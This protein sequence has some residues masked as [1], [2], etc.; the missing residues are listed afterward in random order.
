MRVY[1][2]MYHSILH[3][4]E[5]DPVLAEIREFVR[6]VFQRM[7]DHSALAHADSQ[8]YTNEEYAWLHAGLPMISLRRLGYRLQRMLMKTLGSL[9]DGIALGWRAGFDSGQSLD[10]VYRN[11]PQGK[12]GIGRILDKNYLNSAG[13]CGIRQR[14]VHMERL[15]R[16][17]IAQTQ[18]DYSQPVS[19]VDFAGGPGRYVL[20]VVKEMPQDSYKVLIRD[21]SEEGLDQ[22]RR[23]AKELGLS[24]IEY[25]RG[26]AFSKESLAEIGQVDI[27][28]VSGLYEL[29]SSNEMICRSLQGIAACVKPGGYLIYTGQPWHPQLEMIAEVLINRD[30][31]PWVMRRRTQAEMDELVRAQ[32]FTKLRME[33]DNEQI[34]TVSLAQ[35]L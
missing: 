4:K 12:L 23:I 35:R 32:G 33:L 7:V 20:D 19:I 10:Y 31:K 30:G 16:E 8:G 6:G 9:S 14:K 5:R 11:S 1:R 25:R 34:F 24:G 22:G 28:I 15:L 27:A 2:G 18:K 17:A 3:E 21:W 26:D 29:F 13:W